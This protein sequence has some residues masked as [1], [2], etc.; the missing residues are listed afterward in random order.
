MKRYKY[1]VKVNFYILEDVIRVGLRFTNKKHKAT[2]ANQFKQGQ[3]YL[4]Y[5][6]E[7]VVKNQHTDDLADAGYIELVESEPY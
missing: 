2:I 5:D 3:Q 7:G 1:I 6:G 4:D